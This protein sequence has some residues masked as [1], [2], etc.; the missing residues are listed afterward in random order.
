MLSI[1]QRMNLAPK[2]HALRDACLVTKYIVYVIEANVL[3]GI[4]RVRLDQLLVLCRPVVRVGYICAICPA[5]K[6]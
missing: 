3:A 2:P 4:V 6:T 5:E 1:V